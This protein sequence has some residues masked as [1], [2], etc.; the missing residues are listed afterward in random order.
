MATIMLPPIETAALEAFWHLSRI[1]G[2]FRRS[3]DSY[4]FERLKIDPAI[5]QRPGF[6]S[7]LM[8]IE[9]PRGEIIKM[10][11]HLGRD[12]SRDK[13][14]PREVAIE[15]RGRQFVYDF[16]KVKAK[17]ALHPTLRETALLSHKA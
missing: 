16:A 5:G 11:C 2:L 10:T 3:A 17:S 4:K 15:L 14:F 6:A 8:S 12:T 13:W 7:V 1:E 9:F